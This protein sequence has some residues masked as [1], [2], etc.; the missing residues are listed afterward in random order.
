MNVHPK[1]QSQ[2][3]RSKRTLAFVATGMSDAAP[4]IHGLAMF[5]LDL[6]N[7]KAFTYTMIAK[8]GCLLSGTA[9][10]AIRFPEGWWP[11]RFDM[12]S[13]HSFMH[14]LVV[15]AAVIQ[16]I[17]YLDAFDYAYSHMM[18]SAS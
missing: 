15:C 8:V 10:Y 7:R 11:E 5:G 17:G 3:Y 13:S 9:L 4:F 2:K 1:L 18:C 12:C 14:I 16:I 6:M